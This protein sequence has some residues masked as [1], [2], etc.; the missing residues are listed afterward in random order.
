MI[1]KEKAEKAK[2][3]SN[4]PLYHQKLH[5]FLSGTIVVDGM[6][7]GACDGTGSVSKSNS[8]KDGGSNVD[9]DEWLSPITWD[10]K[11]ASIAAEKLSKKALVAEKCYAKFCPGVLSLQ[12]MHQLM[13]WRILLD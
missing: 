5:S 8:K 13:T 4:E 7:L 10:K 11:D 12:E 2:S 1:L 3:Q 6:S 9:G